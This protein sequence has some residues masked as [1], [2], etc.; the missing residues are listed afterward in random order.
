MQSPSRTQKKASVRFDV[1]DLA[2]KINGLLLRDAHYDFKLFLE[3]Q[4]ES[5][6]AFGSEFRPVNELR[7]LLR[8]YPGFES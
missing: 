1:S 2:A 5:T 7:P 8:T 6:L 4:A 3:I